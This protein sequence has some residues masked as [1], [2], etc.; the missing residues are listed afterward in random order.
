MTSEISVTLK[1][2]KGFE[3]SWAVFR[4]ETAAELKN[5]IAD[6]FG[7][8]HNLDLTLHELVINVTGI[9]HGTATAAAALG[10]VAIPSSD[11]EKAP[12][13]ESSGD[14][15]DETPA[16]EAA[17]GPSILDRIAACASVD[18]LKALWADNQA[19]FNDASVMEAWKARGR[20][21]KAAA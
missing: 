19:A 21:L 15:W 17:A 4:G 7:L 20:E 14:L 18:D 12:A 3:E 13:A 8:D 16:Q 10:A 9:A 6:Y 1:Y 11:T 2:G 5:S